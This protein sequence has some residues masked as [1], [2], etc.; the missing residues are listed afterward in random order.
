[1]QPPV[2]FPHQYQHCGCTGE[3]KSHHTAAGKDRPIMI[4]L[5]DSNTDISNIVIFGIGM[6]LGI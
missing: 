5:A 1:M 2:I 3:T 6:S 4:I